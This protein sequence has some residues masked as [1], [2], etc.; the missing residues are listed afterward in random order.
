MHKRPGHFVF[1]VAGFKKEVWKSPLQVSVVMWTHG[2][3]YDL[4]VGGKPLVECDE[5]LSD[6]VS[7]NRVCGGMARS[8]SHLYCATGFI[9][10]CSE[11]RLCVNEKTV[12]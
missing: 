8:E 10:Y 2:D 3:K 1:V 11:I 9:V 12:P 5:S 6:K 4:Q 7:R